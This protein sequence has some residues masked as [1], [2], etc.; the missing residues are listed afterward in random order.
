MLPDLSIRCNYPYKGNADGFTTYLRKQFSEK[1]YLG[2]E[3][4]IN[5]KHIITSNLTWERIKHQLGESV[6]LLQ[7]I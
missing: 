4:E 3:L 5:Q 6:N 1:K 7:I 2:I